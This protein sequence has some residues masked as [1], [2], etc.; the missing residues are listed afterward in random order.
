[1]ETYVSDGMES[2]ALPLLT[3]TEEGDDTVLHAGDVINRRHDLPPPEL[4]LAK[5]FQEN[6]DPS[7]PRR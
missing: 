2:T 3:G 5:Y 6:Q 1:M 7:R 4:F